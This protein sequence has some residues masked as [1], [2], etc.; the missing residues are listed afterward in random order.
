MFPLIAQH[1]KRSLSSFVQSQN[2][3]LPNAGAK[4]SA[5]SAFQS[6]TRFASSPFIV[7]ATGWDKNAFQSRT[8]RE[9]NK[10]GQD[11]MKRH[12][13]KTKGHETTTTDKNKTQG[14]VTTRKH[15][16]KTL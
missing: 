9:F 6:R 16:D 7:I 14:Q 13:D 15:R 4:V 2:I 8:R 3:S 11:E 5:L 1:G 10:H 12:K